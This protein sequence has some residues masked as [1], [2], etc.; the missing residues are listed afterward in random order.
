MY[1]DIYREREREKQKV[2][3]VKNTTTIITI[4]TITAVFLVPRGDEK[5]RFQQSASTHSGA[6]AKE[7]LNINVVGK[8]IT[9]SN[10]FAVIWAHF[11]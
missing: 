9:A 4:I 1:I 2:E 7:T 8:I 10:L 3:W 6:G 5:E 11:S